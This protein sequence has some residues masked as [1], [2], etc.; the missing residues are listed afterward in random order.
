MR[1][2][3]LGFEALNT[4]FRLRP[5]CLTECV[6]AACMAP[7]AT[8]QLPVAQ[9]VKRHAGALKQCRQTRADNLT[10]NPA[11]R[12]VCNVVPHHYK[13]A[14]HITET[15][16]RAPP[17]N[18]VRR[19]PLK[20]NHEPPIHTRPSHTRSANHDHDLPQPPLLKIA[21]HMRAHRHHLQQ[22]KRSHR[23][24]RIPEA[25]THGRATQ[26]TQRAT[27]LSGPRNDSRHRSRIQ[28]TPTRRRLL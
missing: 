11:S 21:R 14:R 1:I 19:H 18:P 6:D 28:G 2:N 8:D 12:C 25:S 22:R 20:S 27:R 5:P 9:R 13:P 24:C 10:K 15:R 16:S 7:D 3:Q 26:T 4:A 17:L 23:N